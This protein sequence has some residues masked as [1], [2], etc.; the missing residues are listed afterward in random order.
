[1]HFDLLPTEMYQLQEMTLEKEKNNMNII[2][3]I[4]YFQYINPTQKQIIPMPQITQI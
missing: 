4:T 2:Y 3:T 1:M